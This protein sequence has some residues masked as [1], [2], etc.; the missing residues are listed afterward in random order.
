ML[1]YWGTE[2]DEPTVLDQSQAGHF[3]VGRENSAEVG[4]QAGEERFGNSG[5]VPDMD[6][7]HLGLFAEICTRGHYVVRIHPL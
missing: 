5:D 1:A 2:S 3:A 4:L 7:A 6:F